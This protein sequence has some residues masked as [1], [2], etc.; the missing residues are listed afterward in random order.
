MGQRQPQLRLALREEGALWN[1]YLAPPTT[2][3]GAKL[4]ASVDRAVVQDCAEIRTAFIAFCQV[5]MHRAVSMQF[6]LRIVDF[7]DAEVAPEHER[8]GRG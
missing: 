2:M 5:A 4:L 3:E 1:A 6:G 7:G 8:A